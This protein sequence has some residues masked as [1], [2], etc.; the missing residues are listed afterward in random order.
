MRFEQQ[1]KVPSKNYLGCRLV[2]Q[3]DGTVKVWAPVRGGGVPKWELILEAPSMR[4]AH[5]FVHNS[6]IKRG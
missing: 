1:E 5:N 2:R 4:Q 3:L 6:R